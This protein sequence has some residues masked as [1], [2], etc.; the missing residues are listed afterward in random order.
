MKKNIWCDEKEKEFDKKKLM[1]IQNGISIIQQ[2]K[3]WGD[4]MTNDDCELN[5][6]QRLD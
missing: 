2:K 4:S 6:Q 5:M 1:L 3:I